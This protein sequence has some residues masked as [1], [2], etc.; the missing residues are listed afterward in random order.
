MTLA[1][2]D[3]IH[4]IQSYRVVLNGAQAPG[5]QVESAGYREE[6]KCKADAMAAMSSLTVQVS[7]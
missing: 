3:I 1:R 5:V 7:V 6:L 2:A 4:N